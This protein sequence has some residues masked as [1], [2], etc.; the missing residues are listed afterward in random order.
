MRFSGRVS[1]VFFLLCISATFCH[2]QYSSSVQGVITDSSGAAVAGANIVLRNVNTGVE[3]TIS[4]STSGNYSFPTLAP[5]HYL[6]RVEGKG[7][8]TKE[9]DITLG[10]AETQGVNVTL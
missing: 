10:T 4:S 2:A 7:L 8:Q 5:G 3:Q 9:V 6:L 1:V